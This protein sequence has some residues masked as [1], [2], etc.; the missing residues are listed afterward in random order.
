MKRLLPLLTLLLFGFHAFAAQ[1]GEL[2]I[3]TSATSNAVEKD[4]KTNYLPKIKEMA[5]AQGVTVIE[6]VVSKGAPENITYSPAMVFQNHLGRSLYIGRY[7]YV[8]KLK[9]FIRTVSRM[10]QPPATNEKHNVLVW[11]RERSTVFSPVKITAP[12]GAVPAEFDATKFL[13]AA[14]E[15]TAKGATSYTLHELYA[16]QRTDRAMYWALYPFVADDGKLYLSAE[17]YSQFNCIEPI[18]K[19]FDNPFA[20]TWKN[21][22]KVFE[23]AGKTMQAEVEKQLLSTTHGDGMTPLP[24]SNPIKS[25]E[26][27]GLT[28]PKAPSGNDT[29]QVVNLTLGTKWTFAGPIE[30]GT[31]VVNFSFLAP[32]DT[33]AGEVKNL[34]GDLTLGEGASILEALGKFGIE[35]S[36][37]TMGDPSLDHSVHD[38][39]AIVDNPKAFFTLQKITSLEHPQLAFGSLTQFVVAG[40]LEF[41]KINAPLDVTA[42][43]EP[44]LDENGQARLIVNASFRLRLKEKY[45]IDGPDGPMPSADTMQFFLNFLLKPVA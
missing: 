34:F 42:Q 11:K 14:L 7:H 19:R 6:K 40:E 37:L 29:K 35:T 31:P 28:L 24:I 23:E 25:W 22:E 3:F 13:K 36:S 9:T 27:L 26:D 32:M 10:P 20:G 5:K 18:F 21:W 17:M 4:F 1:G 43:I 2:V 39:I 38:M 33:Y 30:E 41:M 44:V 12:N 15:A 16:A 8:D 45:G